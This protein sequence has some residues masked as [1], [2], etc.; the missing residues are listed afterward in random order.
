MWNEFRMTAYFFP[1]QTLY[2][3]GLLVEGRGLRLFFGGDSFTMAGIDDY[4][5]GNR[6]LLGK[7][8]GY[9][10]CLSLIARLK[11]THIFNCHVDE[12]FT[13]T[14]A[15]IAHM[16]DNLSERERL[17]GEL[18][19][20]DH[21]NYGLDEHWVR[22][23][24]YEQVVAAQEKVQVSLVVTNHSPQSKELTCRPI[25]PLHWGRSIEPQTVQLLP[26]EDVSV[27]FV[28]HLP[29]AEVLFPADAQAVGTAPSQ[30]RLVIPMEVTYDG[31]ELGQFRE[32]ILVLEPRST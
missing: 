8:V 4:C 24:P 2:H 29:A 21:A 15:E 6:N 13:F 12:A 7:D 32:A 14:E 28:L 18:F 11:P 27:D 20:W 22:C 9:Y 31:R 25:L 17:F 26:H 23:H 16:L 19:P 10:H 5:A 30:R 3:G 1:G